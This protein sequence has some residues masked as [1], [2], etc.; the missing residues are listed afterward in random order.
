MISANAPKTS[1][2]TIEVNKA[3]NGVAGDPAKQVETHGPQADPN[4]NQWTCFR[5]AIDLEK[6]PTSAIA[7]IAADSKY[8]LW[9]NGELAVFEGQLKRGPTP[10]DTYFDRVD[11]TKFLHKGKNTI[12]ILLWYFGKEGFSHKSSGQSGLVFDAQIDGNPVLS[13]TDWKALTH[14]A[15]ENTGEPHPNFRLPESNIRFDAR[16]DL[17]G[18]QNAGFDDSAWPAATALGVPPCAPWKNLVERPIPLWKDYG[19]RDYANATELPKVSNG[20]PIKAK[21]PYNAQVTPYLKIEGPAGQL[22]DLRTDQYVVA[23]PTIRAEY[24]TRDGVQEYE[25]LGWMNGHEVI[26]KIPAGFKI[27]AMNFRET[28]YDT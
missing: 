21:L 8:W 1:Q 6:A 22:V 17:A 5:T 18:W 23:G 25:S 27:H 19:L 20:Q 12:A 4:A 11:L 3:L 14:P 10:S 9:I 28:C 26:Y 24:V 7:R 13:G 15:Y 16:K 2:H